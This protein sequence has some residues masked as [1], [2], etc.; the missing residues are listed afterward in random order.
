MDST[1]PMASSESLRLLLKPTD[2]AETTARPTQAKMLIDLAQPA[3]QRHG[4][5]E[6]LSHA[7]GF[8]LAIRTG[9]IDRK[10]RLLLVSDWLRRAPCTTASTPPG[11][12]R[13]H[14]IA[15]TPC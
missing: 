11:P 3:A 14:R 8:G 9:K 6:A 2:A 4:R 15:D 1:V 7:N 13:Y 10:S 5:R 12:C